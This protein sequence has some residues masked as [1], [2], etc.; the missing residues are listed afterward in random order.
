TSAPGAPSGRGGGAKAPSR[1]DRWVRL[2]AGQA[3][4]RWRIRFPRAT[5]LSARRAAAASSRLRR[6]AHRHRL[7]ALHEVRVHPLRLADHLDLR[8]A[9]QDLLPHDAQLHLGQPHADA[10]M[11]A[12]A[13]GDVLARPLAIDDEL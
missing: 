13:E 7:E 12:E 5:G 4:R 11:D 6:D 2:P 9:A 10:A 1:S 8:E 3:P